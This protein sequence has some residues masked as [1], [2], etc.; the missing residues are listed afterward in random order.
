MAESVVAF[1]L[2]NLS[3]LLENGAKLLSGAEDKIRSLHNKL[4]IINVYLKSSS[5]HGKKNRKEMEQKIV[6]QIRD[7]VQLAGDVIDTFITNVSMDN[8]RTKLG[9][10]LHGVEHT[11]MLHN[12]AGK[13]NK[14]EMEQKI[15]TQIRDVAH[16]AGNVIDTFITVVSMHNSQQE[17]QAGENAPWS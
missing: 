5:D 8:R 1:L 13:N 11:K 2:E 14:K 7:V 4:Q 3:Q 17:N 6:S 9:R 12:V 16:L 10:M 15:V